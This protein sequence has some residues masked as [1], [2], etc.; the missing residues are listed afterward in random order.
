M[1]RISLLSLAGILIATSAPALAGPTLQA[2]QINLQPQRKLKGPTPQLNLKPD[3]VIQNM[4]F[5]QEFCTDQCSDTW[6]RE[7]RV[8]RIKVQQCQWQVTVKNIGNATS[9]P[10]QVSLTYTTI[11]GPAHVHGA[12]P[13]IRPGQAKNVL[14]PFSNR[15]FRYW[16]YDFNLPFKAKADS[17]NTSRESNEGNNTKRQMMRRGG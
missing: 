8:Y 4:G 14:V 17:T 6:A 9:K 10:G 3:L 15:G 16:Y 7:L 13:A 11:A 1:K 5:S 12:M 2:P